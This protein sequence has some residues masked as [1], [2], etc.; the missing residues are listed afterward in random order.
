MQSSNPGFS[1]FY[2]SL[3]KAGAGWTISQ[4]EILWKKVRAQGPG[5][6]YRVYKHETMVSMLK[7]RLSAKALEEWSADP[8]SELLDHELEGLMGGLFPWYAYDPSQ[9]SFVCQVQ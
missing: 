6:T 8:Y 3:V 7:N 1:E 4:A 2:A 9:G 5:G